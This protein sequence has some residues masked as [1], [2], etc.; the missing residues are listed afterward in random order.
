M[1]HLRAWRAAFQGYRVT[2]GVLPADPDS[3]GREPFKKIYMHLASVC[4]LH[5]DELRIVNSG[6]EPWKRQ[7]SNM[8]PA[9][10]DDDKI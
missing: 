5:G 2:G 1:D 10:D 3:H 4:T 9:L 7:C 8:G 6:N